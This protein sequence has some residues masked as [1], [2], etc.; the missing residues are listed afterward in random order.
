M[1]L[2]WNRKCCAISSA[3]APQKASWGTQL[4]R[5]DCGAQ[6][7]ARP[8]LQSNGGK[9]S[10]GGFLTALADSAIWIA[11]GPDEKGRMGFC[12][13][14]DS[15]ESDIGLAGCAFDSRSTVPPRTSAVAL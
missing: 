7:T 8:T 13:R 14:G 12:A 11:R 2:T 4:L 3:A 10:Y 9:T 1:S 5:Q 15:A 6:M